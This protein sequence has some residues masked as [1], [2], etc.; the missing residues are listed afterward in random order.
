MRQEGIISY[1]RQKGIIFGYTT[2]PAL[3]HSGIV[4]VPVYSAKADDEYEADACM[5][6]AMYRDLI[7][8]NNIPAIERYFGSRSRARDGAFAIK[9]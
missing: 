6:G 9:V 4:K 2:R 5:D 1:M 3:R 7:V 8:D